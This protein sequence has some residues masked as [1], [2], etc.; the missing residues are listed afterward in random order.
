MEHGH[1][2]QEIERRIG[3]A[4]NSSY[5]RDFV[6]GGI[7]GTVTTFAIVAG[8]QGAGFSS[9][10]II[11][12]GI[13]NVLADGFSMAASNFSA[14]QSEREDIDRLREIEQR[15]IRLEPEG[16]KAEIRHIL[17]MKGLRGKTLDHAVSDIIGDEGNWIDM[18]LVD[19]YGR[20]PVDPH[21][22][23]AASA[24]FVAFLLCG[25]IPL[26][27]Y[28]LDSTA[29]FRISIL[30]TA[31]TFFLI[32]MIRSFW[33]LKSWWRLGSETLGIGMIAATI[34]YL[35]GAYVGSLQG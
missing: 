29:P 32:G 33:S 13:A 8:V 2:A 21:P 26:M 30:A 15:H 31:F 16:E 11:A 34:A 6:Y 9:L 25:L 19:E 4:S 23:L 5:L 28:L 35:A 3:K 17:R 14:V 7:D 24:T 12:L 10:V 1:S 18:M 22:V 27:P 20:A